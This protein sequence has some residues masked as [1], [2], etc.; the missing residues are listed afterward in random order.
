MGDIRKQSVY[1]TIY[2]YAGFLIGFISTGILMPRF[3]A[4]SHNGVLK[5]LTSYSLIFAQFGSL[6][7]QVATIKF[8]PLFRNKEKGHGG[9]FVLVLLS[10]LIG[11]SIFTLVYYNIKPWVIS[12]EQAKSS[13]FADYFFLVLPLTFFEILFNQ[14]DTY[15]RA[16]FK[17]ILGSFLKEFFQRFLVLA[18]L[19]L[20]VFN[21]IG[22]NT[23]IFLYTAALSASTVIIFIVLLMQGEISIN[24]R[25]LTLDRKLIYSI[26]SVSGF[27]LITG[28]NAMAITQ[29]DSIII[30]YYYDPGLTGIYAITFTYGTLVMMP[31][32]ALYRIASTYISEAFNKNDLPTLKEIQSKSCLNQYIAGLGLFLLLWVNIDNVFRILPESYQSGKYVIFLIGLGNLIH[33]LAGLSSQLIINSPKYKY[34]AIF[35][36]IFLGILV[37]ADLVLI[38]IYGIIG[39]AA[40][41]LMSVFIFN[42]IKYIYLRSAYG[43]QPYNFSY[44][45]ISFVGA[46]AYL[47]AYYIPLPGQLLVNLVLKSSIVGGVMLAGIYFLRI[48]KD[49]NELVDRGLQMLFRK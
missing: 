28:I 20:Y 27:G 11:F 37:T 35:I 13:L 4:E 38:P 43:I 44:L 41:S 26:L 10:G 40:G 21:W 46:G 34:S 5:L 45:Y 16:L 9:F 42:L 18:V 3:L 25:K 2:I 15:A 1:S 8:M 29:I 31:S 12:H 36:V 39:A 19:L 30:N 49:I 24:P 23:F 7:F 32:R 6:G 47:I 22:F 14:I 33:M 48:S 17:S